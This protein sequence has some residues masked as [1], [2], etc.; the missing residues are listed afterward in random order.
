MIGFEITVN[1]IVFY[2]TT[3]F[4]ILSHDV[5]HPPIALQNITIVTHQHH[6]H[7]A[8]GHGIRTSTSHQHHP[9][10][11]NNLI[12]MARSKNTSRRTRVE[13]PDKLW[14]RA[15]SL[16]SLQPVRKVFVPEN[17]FSTNMLKLF[18]DEESADVV[19]QVG[20]QT[21]DGH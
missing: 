12:I 2:H 6:L 13:A 10:Q 8:P 20:G 17:P 11:N 9:H 19:F 7:H 18:M 5:Q 1:H 3:T 4:W 16:Q 15:M 14:T 21:G